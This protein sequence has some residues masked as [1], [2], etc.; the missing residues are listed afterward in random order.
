[1]VVQR[2]ALGLFAGLVATACSAADPGV[3]GLARPGSKYDGGLGLDGG[4]SGN[5]GGNPGDSGL[6]PADGG[7]DSS[8]A[9]TA[10]TG[11]SAYASQQ[12]ATSA[13]MTHGNKSVGVVPNKDAACLTCHKNGGAGP[14]F[15]FA[16]TAFLDKAGTMVAADKEIRVRSKADGTAYITHSDA[17]GNFWLKL[18]VPAGFYPGLSGMRDGAKT[19]LMTA[20]INNGDCNGCHNGVVTDVVY[21]Q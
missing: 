6:P 20:A 9:T 13:K 2:L 18:G 5:D 15:L 17:D 11:A 19:S 10:F 4:N 14:A 21:L 8:A 12:P 3:D 1:M 7:T 16:G